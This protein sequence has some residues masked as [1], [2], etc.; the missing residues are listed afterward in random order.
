M[1]FILFCVTL[2]LSD[3]LTEIPEIGLS[4]KTRMGQMNDCERGTSNTRKRSL[5]DHFGFLEKNNVQGTQLIFRIMEI[6][7]ES[8]YNVLLV[9]SLC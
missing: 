9:T 1:E 5:F 2:D 7:K 3:N 6:Q 8:Y 4:R